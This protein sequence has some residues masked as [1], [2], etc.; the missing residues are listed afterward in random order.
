MASAIV[1][2]DL[3]D[4]K[5]LTQILNRA[6]LDSS[7]RRRLLTDFGVEIEDQIKERF[8]TKVGPD[9]Q[10]WK[11]L[12]EKTKAYYEKRFPGAQPPLVVRGSLRDSTE[13]QVSTW[14]LVVGQTKVYAAPHQF[15][16]ED[17]NIPARPSI[18]LSP[19]DVEALTSIADDFI[20]RRLAKGV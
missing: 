11:G 20:S 14:D 8:D 18:G 1:T 10:T 17:K 5:K 16:W 2:V 19:E 4:L 3:G 7:A 15:G 6:A 12:A 13:T 9:G